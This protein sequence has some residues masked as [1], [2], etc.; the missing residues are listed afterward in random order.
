MV[1]RCRPLRIREARPNLGNGAQEKALGLERMALLS[2]TRRVG[3]K[4]GCPAML[5]HTGRPLGR[6]EFVAELETSRKRLTYAEP[7][8][9]D[10]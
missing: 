7:T 10:R 5:N 6:P 4:P 8:R 9:Q 1:E 2:H 3:D